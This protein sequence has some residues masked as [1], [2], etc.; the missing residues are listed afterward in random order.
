LSRDT[1]NRKPDY[2]QAKGNTQ[3]PIIA[4][5]WSTNSR[6]KEKKLT[7]EQETTSLGRPHRDHTALI[8]KN[9]GG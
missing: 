9:N 1:R 6:P 4:C 2:R 8:R 3:N 7:T 5:M